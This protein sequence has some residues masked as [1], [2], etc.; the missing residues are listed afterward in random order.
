MSLRRE[1]TE[2]AANERTDFAE[3]SEDEASRGRAKRLRSIQAFVP[4][5]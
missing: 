1:F 5:A 3:L 2:P 4:V